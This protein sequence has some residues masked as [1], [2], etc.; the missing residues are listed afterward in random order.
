LDAVGLK[1]APTT[2]RRLFSTVEW[3]GITVAAF[4]LKVHYGMCFI[5]HPLLPS[6][7]LP[8]RPPPNHPPL[9]YVRPEIS[10]HLKKSAQ[11]PLKPAFM[12]S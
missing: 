7:P 3:F 9:C 2:A 12:D 10:A 1:L 5:L 6:A 8:S 11:K 4:W